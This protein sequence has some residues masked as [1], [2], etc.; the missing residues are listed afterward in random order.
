MAGV[1]AAD[2]F[3]GGMLDVAAGIAGFDAGHATQVLEDGFDAPE[4]AAPENGCF[5]GRAGR[6]G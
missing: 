5:G 4:A 6:L 3:V 1:L 2:L